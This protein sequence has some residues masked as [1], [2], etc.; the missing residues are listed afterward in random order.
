MIVEYP[1]HRDMNPVQR[2]VQWIELGIIP[3]TETH[4][5][6]VIDCAVVANVLGVSLYAE[7][8]LDFINHI[9]LTAVLAGN[10][11]GILH[12]NSEVLHHLRAYRDK[13]REAFEDG[14]ETRHNG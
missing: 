1:F 9:S 6:V 5:P 11:P 4:E 8:L 2:L 13:E 14:Q 7:S 12:P 10:V 3:D